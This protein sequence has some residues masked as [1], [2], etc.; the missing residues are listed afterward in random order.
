[1]NYL[2]HALLSGQSE[3][4]LLGNFIADHVRNED[5][6]KY[7][8]AI[9]AGIQLHRQIDTFTDT[10]AAFRASKRVFYRGFEKHSGILV[11][12]YFDHLLASAFEDY[13]GLSLGDFSRRAYET[14]SR[15]QHLLPPSSQ[16]FLSYVISNDIYSAYASEQ[17]IVRVLDHLSKRIRHDVQ[18]AASIELFTAA[19]PMLA[20]HFRTLLTDAL[21]RFR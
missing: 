16:K 18:L 4:L 15:N 2:A 5:L 9:V 14:Y 20:E 1:M 8:E 19:K 7:P 3:D 17:G 12:I 11:D 6:K 21:A 10:H 13:A